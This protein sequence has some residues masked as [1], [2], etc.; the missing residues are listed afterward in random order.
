MKVV[1]SAGSRAAA[2]A[3]MTGALDDLVIEGV[4]TTVP[5][6]QRILAHPD[7]RR[8]TVHTQ[9]VEQGAFNG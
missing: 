6:L 5:V 3:R 9:M 8:G 1:A 2:I 7:F 4:K